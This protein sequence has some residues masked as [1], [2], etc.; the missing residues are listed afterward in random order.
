MRLR[1][2]GWSVVPLLTFAGL[3]SSIYTQFSIITSEANGGGG[4]TST[5]LL[6]GLHLGL[7]IVTALWFYKSILSWTKAVT[8]VILTVVANCSPLLYKY[9][10][11]FFWQD[12]TFPILGTIELDHLAFFF[13]TALVVYIG[14]NFSVRNLP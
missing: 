5:V 14:C 11:G 13:P 7:T 3:V 8:L 2:I 10:P 4:L 9:V 1:R 6:G 12:K